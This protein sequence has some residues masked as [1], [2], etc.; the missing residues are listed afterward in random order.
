VNTL[1]D[2][3]ERKKITKKEIFLKSL[4]YRG[5][6]VVYEFLLYLILLP[7]LGVQTTALFIIINNAVKILGYIFFE[8]VWFE[9]LRIKFTPLIKFLKRYL[10]NRRG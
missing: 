5:Y 2:E 3:E 6:V 4:L 10:R 9:H 8:V 7:F 1:V